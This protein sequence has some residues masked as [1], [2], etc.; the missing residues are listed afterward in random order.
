MFTTLFHRLTIA[1]VSLVSMLFITPG[2]YITYPEAGSTI[3][4]IVEIRGSIPETDFESATISYAYD[5]SEVENWFQIA[6]IDAPMQDVVL[7]KWDTTTITDGTYQLKLSVTTTSGSVNE[8]IIGQISVKN[9]THP[10][11]T[12]LPNVDSERTR[13]PLPSPE[14]VELKQP[15]PLPVNPAAADSEQLKTSMVFGIVIAVMALILLFLY[16]TIRKSRTRR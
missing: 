16:S 3:N 10:A 15:T 2:L 7:A 4:G 5:G 14:T 1:F 13:I 12:T 8:V 9:Y 11:A 6:K